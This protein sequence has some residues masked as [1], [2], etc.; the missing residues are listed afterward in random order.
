MRSVQVINSSATE[1]I[2]QIK[3]IVECFC[4]PGVIRKTQFFEDTQ[5]YHFDISGNKFC[6]RANRIHNRNNCY[7]RYNLNSNILGTINAYSPEI[8]FLLYLFLSDIG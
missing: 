6:S 1:K 2:G 8:F 4:M 5:T 7:Y 3:D